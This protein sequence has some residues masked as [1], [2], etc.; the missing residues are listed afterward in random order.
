MKV[1]LGPHW[2]LS[3]EHAACSAGQPLL[4]DRSTGDVYGPDD[5]VQPYNT[6]NVMPAAKAVVRLAE[7]Q[8]LDTE[9]QALVG[10]FLKRLSP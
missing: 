1:A 4:V 8:A 10:R 7:T 9:A 2:E 6:W 3:N 5:I